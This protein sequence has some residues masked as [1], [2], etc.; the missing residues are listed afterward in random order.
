MALPLTDKAM[1]VRAADDLTTADEIVHTEALSSRQAA[2]PIRV[3]GG[4]AATEVDFIE[5]CE[6]YLQTRGDIVGSGV[7]WRVWL[8][9]ARAVL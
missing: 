3:V 2:H 4:H 7:L 8:C 9:G 5:L 6:E 1:L